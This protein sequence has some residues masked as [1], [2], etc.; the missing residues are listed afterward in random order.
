MKVLNTN[1]LSKRLLIKSTKTL[2]SLGSNYLHDKYSIASGGIYYFRQVIHCPIVIIVTV[3]LSL[4]AP[5]TYL[6]R[7][8]Y[9]HL[10]KGLFYIRI[11]SYII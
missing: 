7:N 8:N 1:Y 2:K 3:K 6:N 11:H 4:L 10:L 9:F 5:F